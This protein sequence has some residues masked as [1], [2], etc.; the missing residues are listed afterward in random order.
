MPLL[1]CNSNIVQILE[2]IP[3]EWDSSVKMDF[4]SEKGSALKEKNLL[5]EGANSFL[6]QQTLKEQVLSF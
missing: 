2:Y 6:L 3:F 1:P 4:P 5:P